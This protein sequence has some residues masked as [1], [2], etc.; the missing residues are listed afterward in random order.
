MKKVILLFL[1]LFFFQKSRSQVPERTFFAY[2]SE[3]MEKVLNEVESKFKIKYS[4]ID[5]IISKKKITLP[6]KQYSLE[7]INED[8]E[9]QTTLKI[10]KIDNRFYSISK[11]KKKES[12]SIKNYWLKDVL[13]E[14]FL[15]KGINKT[16]QKFIIY[17]QK[18]ETLPGVTDADILLSLQQLPGV[19]SPNETASGLHVR[20]GT[21]DQNLILW[22]GIR[23]YHPGHLFGMISG[24]NPNVNQ[25]VTYYN[26]STNPKFGERI[27]SVID[28]KSSDNITEKLKAKA[29]IN[30]LNADLYFQVPLLKNKLGLQLSGRKS[31]TE[32]LQLPTFNQLADKVFQNT[33]FTDFDN[34]NQFRFQDYSGKLNYKPSANT[35]ISVTG[36]VIDNNLDFTT[37]SPN[38]SVNTQEMAIFNQGYSLNWTQNFSSKWK[39]KFL[40]FYSI[41]DFDYDKKQQF[42]PG[43]FEAFRKLN[44]IVDSGV[45]LNWENVFSNNWSID[46]GYQV[47]GNDVSHL[48]SSY[49]QNIAFDLSLKHVYNI[50]HVGYTSLKYD[51]SN[52]NLH[53]GLRY[54][55]FAKI[56][57]NSFEPRLFIQRTL[58]ENLILQVSYERKSQIVSQVREN[59]AND[60]SLENYVWIV[61]ENNEYP[62][63]RG[64]QFTSGLIFKKNNWLVDVDLYYKTITGIT[65]FTLG[66]INQAVPTINR[67]EGFTKGID[68]LVQKSTP[69][70]RAWMTY[71]YQ[72]SQN[73][74]DGI[75]QDQY[76]QINSNIKHA[77]N[78][79]FNKKWNDFSLAL[80]W[81]LHSGKPYSLL[82]S[83][84]QIATF[85]ADRLPSYHR[86]DISAIYEFFKAEVKSFKLGVSIY[87]AYNR[88]TII[89]KELE[90]SY[91]N[92]IDYSVPNYVVQDYYSLGITPN[93]FLR[94]N[95]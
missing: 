53:G 44:R 66:F 75:N 1:L 88:K 79:A 90:R 93:I 71:T 48:F 61:A 13:V 81:F 40:V 43:S 15:A 86:L 6:R 67:G 31:F 24:I 5:S 58:F 55:S 35:S 77:F 19:K 63:Q 65:S 52:W 42:N 73:K 87:N 2:T 21:S 84:S 7:E 91:A 37:E 46:Y 26:K 89:N 74:F 14:G 23:L 10:T 64:N 27:S 3:K 95:F 51:A 54:N 85:N 38:L 12:D 11:E 4:Y 78:V 49:N 30:A 69:T 70:W 62:V 41:Y 56:D 72:D 34:E 45:E 76:F 18:V 9:N 20:G 36:I 60:L 25:T 94:M 68:I 28:I 83:D 39:Q 80:G 29:G 8:I 82:N 17:P 22:D 92:V 32:W 16:N 50:T 57:A 47:F 59:V 33:N